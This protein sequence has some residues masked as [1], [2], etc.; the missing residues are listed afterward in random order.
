MHEGSFVAARITYS[1]SGQ[2]PLRTVCLCE[3][4]CAGTFASNEC[5]AS[6]LQ[7]LNPKLS[8]VG[9]AVR[10]QQLIKE[11]ELNGVRC[12]FVCAGVLGFV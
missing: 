6:S 9:Q 7:I 1:S 8:Q 3:V 10:G 11:M 12:A 5:G 4:G 2:L